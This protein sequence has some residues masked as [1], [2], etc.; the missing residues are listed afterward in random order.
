MLYDNHNFKSKM[1]KKFCSNENVQISNN[2][3]VSHNHRIK[4]VKDER[5]YTFH[6]YKVLKKQH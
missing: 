2:L 5:L 3:D 6:L 1:N 4:Q